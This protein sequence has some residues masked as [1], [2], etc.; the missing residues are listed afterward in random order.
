MQLSGRPADVG[1]EMSEDVFEERLS[2]IR[3]RFIASLPGKLD[4]TDAALTRMAGEAATAVEAVGET[5]RLMHGIAGT[6]PTVG[7]S[8]TGSAARLAEA[9]LIPAYREQR[10][11][12]PDEITDFKNALPALRSAAA[13]ELHTHS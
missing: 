8:S 1:P 12:R 9:V 10:G 6:G 7:F 3:N 2:K 13:L 11:L 4:D 5:Y